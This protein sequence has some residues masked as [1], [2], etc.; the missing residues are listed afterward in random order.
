MSYFV[1]VCGEI[2]ALDAG[3][4]RFVPVHEA[5][6][7]LSRAV[8]GVGDAE[9]GPFYLWD[10]R[11]TETS[12][13]LVFEAE[14]HLFMQGTIVGTSL[15]LLL[16][17]S[18]ANRSSVYV[19]W[20]GNAEPDLDG[21]PSVSTLADALALIDTQL[22]VRSSGKPDIAMALLPSAQP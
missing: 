1:V 18:E 3:K 7:Y 8:S 21:L 4:G 6:P 19:W 14:E 10:D 15:Y 9:N 20:A 22:G 12:S 5:Q 17:S 13:D 2:S 11:E 16:S